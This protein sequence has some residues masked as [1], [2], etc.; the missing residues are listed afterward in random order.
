MKPSEVLD[1]ENKISIHHS[2]NL[3]ILLH[4]S[5]CYSEKAHHSL[6][7]IVADTLV[8]LLNPKSSWISSENLP[9]FFF[10]LS[11]S[12]AFENSLI[13]NLMNLFFSADQ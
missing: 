9:L 4:L 6:C 11:F 7:L 8:A 5:Y 2:C 10:C 13:T 1:S 3:V 12:F